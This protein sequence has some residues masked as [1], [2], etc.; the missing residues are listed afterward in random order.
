MFLAPLIGIGLGWII[1][2]GI[3]GLIFTFERFSKKS[4]KKMFHIKENKKFNSQEDKYQSKNKRDIDLF[5][6]VS[7]ML[8]YLGIHQSKMQ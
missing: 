6:F 8:L 7:Q 5:G 3:E 4:P 1:T 2:F